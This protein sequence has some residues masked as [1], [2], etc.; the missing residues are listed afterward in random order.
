MYAC[1][2]ASMC[3]SVYL[4]AYMHRYS[5]VCHTWDLLAGQVSD[6]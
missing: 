2:Q 4:S 6:S 3:L 5:H 1:K